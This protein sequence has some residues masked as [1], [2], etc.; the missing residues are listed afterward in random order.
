MR[1]QRREEGGWYAGVPEGARFE[2]REEKREK[3]REKEQ[4]RAEGKGGEAGMQEL[5]RGRR[6]LSRPSRVSRRS[7]SAAAR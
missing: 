6:A 5:M 7:S 2:R 3:R 1:E 4:S